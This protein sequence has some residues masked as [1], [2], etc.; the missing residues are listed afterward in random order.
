MI[1]WGA[2]LKLNVITPTSVAEFREALLQGIPYHA[3]RCSLLDVP[4]PRFILTNNFR[5]HAERVLEL[6]G[7]QDLFSCIIAVDDM[8]SLSAVDVLAKPQIDAYTFAV[9]SMGVRNA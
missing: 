5:G 7:V 8:N 1:V 9:K 3:L 6:L 4:G 2:L